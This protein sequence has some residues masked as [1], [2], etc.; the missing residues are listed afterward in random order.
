V[1]NIRSEI[2]DRRRQF[3]LDANER[4]YREFADSLPEIV[5]EADSTAKLTFL[6]KKAFQI[7]GYS[8]E[9]VAEK[10]FFQFVNPEDR[11]RI[12]DRFQSLIR[13]DGTIN[14]LNPTE[15]SLVSKDGSKIPVMSYIERTTDSKGSPVVRG[16]LVD[17]SESKVAAKRLEAL[18]EKLGVVGKLTR[19]DVRNKLMV[20]LE[21]AYLAKDEAQG[22]P[23]AVTR[24]ERIESAVDKI[25]KILDFSAAYERV[26]VEG[27]SC[28]DV[29]DCFEEA[30]SLHHDMH[31]VKAVNEC[32]G[33]T[34]M[35][36]SLLR[37]ALYNLID[38]SL[39]Y[40][41]T[42]THVRLRC[43]VRDGATLLIYEDDGV[44]ITAMEKEK[45]FTE[46]YGKKTGYCLFLIRKICT[47]Y[48]WTIN[49]EGEPGKGVRFVMTVNSERC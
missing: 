13:S 25:V 17:I 27:L 42:L 28:T 7:L 35:A 18:N 20:I 14:G 30:V 3:Y 4:R 41:K 36:D 21:N 1:P 49:E 23:A 48:G 29:G 32:R 19:H 9:E 33:T 5:Y 38:N 39:K 11:Q 40:G 34:I 43:E 37:Q 10:T 16:I 44:G 15:C 22:A 8:N 31:G 47:S 46:G 12:S 6:N 45:L 24:L 26:G 2:E